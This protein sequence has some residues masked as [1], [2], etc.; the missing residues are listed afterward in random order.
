MKTSLNKLFLLAIILFTPKIVT[1]AS[2]CSY[3]EQAELNN[4]VAN[5]KAT[6]EVVDIY[7]G[8]SYDVDNP[9]ETG[10]FPEVESYIKG[11]NISIL[12]ITEDIYVTV[13]NNA[14]SEVKTFRYQDSNNGV[15][16]FQT[17][18]SEQL[19]TYTIEVFANK[20]ACTGEKFR[21]LYITTPMYNAY[22]DRPICAENKEFYYCQE[23]IPSENIS[24]TEFQKKIE[25]YEK[26]KN[27]NHVVDSSTNNKNLMEKMKEF[28][29]KYQLVI[30]I[31]GVTIVG[32]GVLTTV[33]L[34]KKKRSRLL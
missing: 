26:Q 25:E 12:N 22:S 30:I 33:I 20:Y 23:F 10:H 4:I 2:A 34:I 19:V 3:N 17:K 14:N 21:V 8:I 6:Y 5:V 18:N 29:S 7:N 16:T 31:V 15:V 28:Y 1:A 27:E 13:T 32:A 9:D 11:F 24:Y